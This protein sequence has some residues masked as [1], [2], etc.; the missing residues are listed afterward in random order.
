MFPALPVLIGLVS[1]VSSCKKQQQERNCDNKPVSNYRGSTRFRQRSSTQ[2]LIDGH[3]VCLIW[4]G[5]HMSRDAE[6]QG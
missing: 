4:T 6:Q 3:F 5:M 2:L 1:I